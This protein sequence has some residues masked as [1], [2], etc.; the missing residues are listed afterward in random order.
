MSKEK[1]SVVPFERPFHRFLSQFKKNK[2]AYYSALI[3]LTLFAISLFAEFIANDKPIIAWKAGGVYFHVFRNITE[4]DLG[5]RFDAPVDWKDSYAERVLLGEDGG[6]IM[7]LIPYHYSTIVRNIPGVAPTPPTFDNWLGTDD[8]ARDLLARTIYG[9]RISVFFAFILVF[10]AMII[11]VTVGAVFGYF[12]GK[13]DLWGMRLLEVWGSMPSLYVIII[14][15]SIVGSSFWILLFILLL[16][17]WMSFVGVV[18]AEFFRVR[19]FEF[20]AAAEAMG[21]SPLRIMFKHILPNA[22]VATITNAPFA[23]VGGITAL[24]SL[25]FLGFGLPPGS[26]SLGEMVAQAKANLQ[27]PWIGILAFLSIGILLLLL[28]FIGEG[29]RDALDSRR[30]A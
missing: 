6:M 24:T 2:L 20:V 8:K 11:G 17:S 3:F 30:K 25:D 16:F 13:I 28:I 19:N 4:K 21:Q 15:T 12:G 10:F 23:F 14:I 5:G 18:R 29:V 22:A 9:F 27:A 1:S 26:A 7:P